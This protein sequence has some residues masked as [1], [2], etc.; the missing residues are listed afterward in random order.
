MR[1]G[2]VI[3][4]QWR[5]EDRLTPPARR[6]VSQCLGPRTTDLPAALQRSRRNYL[7]R[8][9]LPSALA[10]ASSLAPAIAQIVCGALQALALPAQGTG[11][12]LTLNSLQSRPS[13]GVPSFPDPRGFPRPGH[14]LAPPPAAG[15]GRGMRF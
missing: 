1:S 8:S 11:L 15:G 9:R 5:E 6:R 13:F 4:A 3:G 14:S 2:T 7:R 12:K 10:R